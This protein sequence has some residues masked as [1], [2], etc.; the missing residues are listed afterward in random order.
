[1]SASRIVFKYAAFGCLWILA[2]DQ[3]LELVFQNA[4]VLAIAQSCK[5]VAFVLV[6]ALLLYVLVSQSETRQAQL[7]QATL[8][9]KARLS[10]ILNVSPAVT[11]ALRWN[12]TAFEVDFISQ[13]IESVLGYSLA[14]WL[15]EPDFWRTRI[16]PDDRAQVDQAQQTLR[17]QHH[18]T[19]EYRC[20][21]A[22]GHYRWIHD[23]VLMD[24]DAQ[25]RPLAIFGAW[26]D[27][28][29]RRNA[30]AHLRLIDQVFEG[31]QEGI[32]VTD[33]SGRMVSVNRAFTQI[34][35]YTQDDALGNRPS[36][37]SSG[38]Q[39]A[40]FYK[41]LWDCV[42]A[43][44]RWEG[45]VW[46]RRKAGDIYPEWLSISAIVDEHGE[47]QQYL[48]I[49]S[50][51]SGKK[52]AEAR[53][54]RLANYD[55]LTGLPNRTLL[56][57]RA[58]VACAAAQRSHESV[59]VMHLNLDH[60]GSVNESLGHDMGDHVLIEVAR[61]LTADLRPEDTVC[62]MGG[63]N[64]IILLPDAST[65]D[66]ANLA[67]RLMDGIAQPMR[68]G[69]HEL[70]LSASVGIASY[71][72][73]GNDL[74]QLTKSAEWAVHRAKKEGR[75][76]FQF[77][78]RSLQ[79]EAM[80]TLTMERELRHAVERQQLVLHYQPQI[81]IAT[82]RIIGIEALIRWQHPEWGL[83]SP[84]QFI[85][86]AE[87][88]GLIR[89]IGKWVLMTAAHQNAQW[90]REGFEAVP[91][92]I[93]LSFAQFKDKHLMDIVATALRES[94]LPPR[95]MEL[96]LTESVAMTDSDFTVATINALKRLGVSLS[97]DDFGTGYSSLSQLKCLAV[98][99]LKIDQS[100]VRGLNADRN[101]E[102]IVRTVVGL[103][104]NLGLKTIAEG[105]ETPKQLAFLKALGC[106]EF[107]G[108]LFSRPVP[109]AQLVLLLA[110][111]EQL[112]LACG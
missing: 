83:V 88:S 9:D 102:A 4:E 3:L 106:D 84:G 111:R 5:G 26:L 42:R 58:K 47:V 48:G 73:D 12:G 17:E 46:N 23:N 53:I 38:C 21:H 8:E 33:K 51:T 16:H 32:M 105:V 45:E 78:S 31:S 15:G 104:K 92:A 34:T 67:V 108:Y 98:D 81:D 64:F 76:Q 75:E 101:D 49:F 107:Q 103:A 85:P 65:H 18:V 72:E 13:N 97:I 1:M 52:A 35:G 44:G 20:L 39:D 66:I 28:T 90:L 95:L 59:V 79:D 6:S 71:P 82:H 91:V 74:V 50:E 36:L 27:V 109:A 30:E 7:Q 56:A 93:N 54:Q 40:P 99:K 96:E 25:G 86:I 29:E 14:E 43:E 63:D 62:R 11:Y 69:A 112:V 89:D 10:H 37:L 80:R 60:F 24:V 94:G 61:R 70:K 57:D 110:R 68:I 77:S 2:S 87:E 55:A 100:F 41:A 19:H 22:D